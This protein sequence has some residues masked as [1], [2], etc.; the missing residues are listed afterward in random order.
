M[1][2]VCWLAY[3]CYK[4]VPFI[5]VMNAGGLGMIP[6]ILG[7]VTRFNKR[8]DDMV[9]KI[10]PHCS[11]EDLKRFHLYATQDRFKPEL[12]DK[13]QVLLRLA[14]KGKDENNM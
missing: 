3:F 2:T 14:N 8:I 1:C 6:L 7:G 9:K 4:T 5:F 10:L 11:S 12:S 13:A